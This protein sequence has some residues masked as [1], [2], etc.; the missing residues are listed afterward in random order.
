MRLLARDPEL[1]VLFCLNHISWHTVFEW[2]VVWKGTLVC[3]ITL[4]NLIWLF[5]FKIE[6]SNF[7]MIM[8]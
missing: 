8:L 7:L 2:P 6:S 1:V 4:I 5:M 3:S